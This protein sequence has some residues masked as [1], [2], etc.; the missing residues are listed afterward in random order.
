MTVN[1]RVINL[2]LQRNDLINIDLRDGLRVQILPSIMFLA[3]CQRHQNAAFIK[4]RAI[5]VVWA[6]SPQ[7]VISRAEYIEAKMMEIFA[8]GLDPYDEKSGEGDNPPV[9]GNEATLGTEQVDIPREDGLTEGPRKIVLN[10]AVLCAITIMLII[11]A[12]GT[13]WRQI[14]I[15]IA[16][17]HK[18]LRL[19][20][21]IVVPLQVWLALVCISCRLGKGFSDLACLI[22]SSSCNLLQDLWP[23]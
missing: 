12:L 6:D 1:T 7:E 22:S 8:R 9:F 5:L 3:N 15:E 10:Q 23:S 17:D 14:A 4:D 19:A 20:F 11:A 2:L 21:F 16:V 18:Y 13:G